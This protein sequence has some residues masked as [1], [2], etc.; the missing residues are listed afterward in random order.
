MATAHPFLA[1]GTRLEVDGPRGSAIVVVRDRGPEAWTGRGLD[2]SPA[3]FRAVVG[4]LRLG[5]GP[6]S[7]RVLS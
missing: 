2:L 1:L 3:A 6:V 7:Y 5:I 4:P